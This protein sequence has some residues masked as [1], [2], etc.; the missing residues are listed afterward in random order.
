MLG[1]G[2]GVCS[3]TLI[4][5]TSCRSLFPLLLL[6]PTPVPLLPL[7]LEPRV[8]RGRTVGQPQLPHAKLVL[9]HPRRLPPVEVADER[10]RLR[11]GRPLAV[12]GRAGLA[13]EA[14]AL[15]ALC[16]RL[17]RALVFD[18]LGARRLVGGPAVV[19]VVAERP[20]VGVDGVEALAVVAVV[21]VF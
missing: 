20:E 2:G 17:E 10:R 5:P 3:L 12:D 13:R 18:D 7:P 4:P 11:R 1:K 16:E 15:V 8:P 19:Q 21:G 14:E 6:L 9:S